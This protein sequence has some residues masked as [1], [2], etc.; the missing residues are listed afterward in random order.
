MVGTRYENQRREL[1][2]SLKTKQDSLKA[3]HRQGEWQELIKALS[4]APLIPTYQ[5]ILILSKLAS[6]DIILC[7]SVSCDNHNIIITVSQ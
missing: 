4:S 7:G 3:K 1:D 6:Y 2:K 5:L